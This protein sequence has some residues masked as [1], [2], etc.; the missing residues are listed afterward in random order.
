MGLERQ[1]L[2]VVV[3]LNGFLIE[4]FWWRGFTVLEGVP[5]S[6]SVFMERSVHCAQCLDRQLKW[7]SY[8]GNA[9]GSD[10]EGRFQPCP[11]PCFHWRATRGS[12]P[13]PL[14]PET[15]ALSTE[16]VAPMWLIFKKKM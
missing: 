14:V 7:I 12:N 15:N 4:L 16:L 10:A 2:S 9:V 3:A 11:S 5:G 1:I 8:V 6:K 13:G